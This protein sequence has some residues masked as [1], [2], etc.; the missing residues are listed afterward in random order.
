MYTFDNVLRYIK[1]QKKM[2]LC[3]GFTALTQN[4]IFLS[5]VYLFTP[6]FVI[7]FLFVI[8]LTIN[9]VF[10][11][12]EEFGGYRQTSNSFTCLITS[13]YARFILQKRKRRHSFIFIVNWNYLIPCQ[14]RK[15][16]SCFC[17]KKFGLSW[18]CTSCIN[19]FKEYL[20]L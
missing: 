9:Q 4:Y 13:Y 7:A 5:N 10:V 3:Q 20:L 18:F 2:T 8:L 11:T 14:L 6:L 1:M 17:S 16:S 19:L 15:Y 12:S